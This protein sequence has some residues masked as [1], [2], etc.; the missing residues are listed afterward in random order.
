V[1]SRSMLHGT[2]CN[3]FFLVSCMD[4]VYSHSSPTP[5]CF[6]LDGVQMGGGPLPFCSMT[7]LG[8]IRFAMAFAC[9]S[10]LVAMLNTVV[11]FV[12]VCCVSHF[13]SLCLLFT[14]TGN[15]VRLEYGVPHP[16]MFYIG[17]DFPVP[18]HLE[19]MLLKL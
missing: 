5:P 14:L 1:G 11:S 17:A 19:L 16:R 18:L 9:V 4:M 10:I 12:R 13:L 15:I 3:H 8:P 7:V 6:L 2:W